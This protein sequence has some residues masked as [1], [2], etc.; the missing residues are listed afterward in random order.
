MLSPASP[1]TRSAALAGIRVLELGGLAPSP[2]CGMILADFGADV[3]RVDNDAT[4]PLSKDD[5]SSLSSQTRHFLSRNKRSIVLNLKNPRHNAVFR[6]MAQQSDVL[7][8]PFRPGTMERLGLGSDRL[9]QQNERL[10]YARLT[11][12]GQYGSLSRKAGH[13]INYLAIS[14]ALSTMARHKERPL[15]PVNYLAD[16]SGGSLMCV[17][18]ILLALLERQYSHQGQV[19]DCS[20]VDG[21]N[22]MSA[23]LHKMRVSSLWDK[24]AASVGTNLLDSGAPFYDTYT[25]LDGKCVAVGAIEPQFYHDLLVGLD[26]EGDTS[27]PHQMDRSR[28]PLLRRKIENAFVRKTRDEWSQVFDDLDACVTPVLS[29][30]EV[31]DHPHNR[32]RDLLDYKS[33]PH[34][35]PNPEPAPR[36]SRSPATE[37]TTSTWPSHTGEHTSEVLGEF[38][39]D[40]SELQDD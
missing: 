21:V 40:P 27:L 10:I 8:E 9:L 5:Y 16:F 3:I 28:W 2:F 36:L 19:I 6:Q 32:E 26:L 11:G 13:D 7:I 15:A 14:G 22:Y 31:T 33:T 17:N 25:C 35:G 34:D 29:M 4:P 1:N 38:G 30:D 12:Y 24:Q 18:G 39:I 23:F 20:M 37:S